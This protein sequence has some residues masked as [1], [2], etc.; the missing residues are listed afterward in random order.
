M[1]HVWSNLFTIA[2]GIEIDELS[3]D[4]QT[5]TTVGT[6]SSTDPPYITINPADPDSQATYYVYA[7]DNSGTNYSD[8]A[9][10]VPGID[11]PVLSVASVGRRKGGHKQCYICRMAYD[12]FSGPRRI[13]PWRIIWTDGMVNS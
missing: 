2:T 12:P 7:T 9:T 6:P 13:K 1:T 5:Y 4:G 3:G 8:P 10:V 11:P